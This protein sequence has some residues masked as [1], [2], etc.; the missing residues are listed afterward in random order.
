MKIGILNCSDIARIRMIPAMKKITDIEISV[1]C[2]REIKKAK[3]F[4]K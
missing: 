1:I 4:A 2:S 3:E